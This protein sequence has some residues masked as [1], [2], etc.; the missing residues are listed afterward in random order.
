MILRTGPGPPTRLLRGNT[1][2]RPGTDRRPADGGRPTGH[3]GRPDLCVR[4]CAMHTG[5][6]LASSPRTDPSRSSPALLP[7]P[8]F[9]PSSPRTGFFAAL[10]A[11][12]TEHFFSIGLIVE[13]GAQG[14]DSRPSEE[15]A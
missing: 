15:S 13:E 5:M 7:S 8:S 2:V 3:D 4:S 10:H 1:P 6:A 12:Q 14:A 9:S 11:P